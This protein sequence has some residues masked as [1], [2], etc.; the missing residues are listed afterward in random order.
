MSPSNSLKM[1]QRV[2]VT[3]LRLSQG[4]KS[5]QTLAGSSPS[6]PPSNLP[7]YVQGALDE[8]LLPPGRRL[9]GYLFGSHWGCQ[10][11]PNALSADSRDYCTT[12]SHRQKHTAKGF[13][14][15]SQY[16]P[17]L[18]LN[19]ITPGCKRTVANFLKKTLDNVLSF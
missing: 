9:A 16:M 13:Q 6:T 11:Q 7:I 2:Q 12:V 4:N 3:N 15:S 8:A 1:R 19:R 17:A 18:R 10:L 5:H 14:E